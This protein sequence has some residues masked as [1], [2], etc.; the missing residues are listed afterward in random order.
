MERLHPTTDAE[1]AVDSRPPPREACERQPRALTGHGLVVIVLRR[2]LRVG[3]V[4]G[5]S[6]V[7]VVERRGTRGREG[8]WFGRQAQVFEDEFDRCRLG[9][10]L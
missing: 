7:D 4:E 5:G 2:W 8:R 6:L 1:E 10:Y 3:Q 9:Y